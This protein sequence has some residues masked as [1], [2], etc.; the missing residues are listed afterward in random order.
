MNRKISRL[1]K[2]IDE[3]IIQLKAAKSKCK[4]KINKNGVCTR[5]GEDFGWWCPKSPDH[6]CH[7]YTLD[8]EVPLIDGRRARAPKKH[9]PFHETGDSCIYC[10]EPEERK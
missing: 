5:C 3:F 7:Y 8:D 10:G 4:H 9:N 6:V 2:T 1:S